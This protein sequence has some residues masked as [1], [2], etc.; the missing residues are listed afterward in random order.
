MQP[1]PNRT[2]F[3]CEYSHTVSKDGK[4][5]SQFLGEKALPYKK[6]PIQKHHSHG[7]HVL[8]NY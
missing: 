7:K 4:L 8:R 3:N 5:W 2:R 1:H 6:C